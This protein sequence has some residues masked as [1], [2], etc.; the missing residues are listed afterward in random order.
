[1]INHKY[2]YIG[3]TI[4]A[5]ILSVIIILIIVFSHK[6][7]KSHQPSGPPSPPTPQSPPSPPTP[8]SP[9]PTPQ[10]PPTP[11]PP[12]TKTAALMYDN[13]GLE[14]NAM[15]CNNDIIK[16]M[17]TSDGLYSINVSNPQNTNNGMFCNLYNYNIP[18]HISNTD[19]YFGQLNLP[20][21]T[22]SIVF[23]IV[24]NDFN[25]YSDCP[26]GHICP[27]IQNWPIYFYI[28]ILNVN[29][30][31]IPIPI[32]SHFNLDKDSEGNITGTTTLQFKG[33]FTTTDSSN[34]IRLDIGIQGGTFMRI[35]SASSTV[36][37][38]T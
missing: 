14:I 15:D 37:K 26:G 38:L 27:T 21:G 33:T 2:L 29:N 16:Y 36:N 7:S 22:Y 20:K 19:L 32:S 31:K 12:I 8:Q 30:I 24:F 5:I 1:M 28:Y 34:E 9:P 25:S 17:L 18:I 4:G 10:S 11:G 3:I 23:D 13:L 6:T 35:I